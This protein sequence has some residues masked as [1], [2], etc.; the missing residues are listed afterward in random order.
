MSF[1]G[2]GS[3]KI[4]VFWKEKKKS[5]SP[6][7]NFNSIVCPWLINFLRCNEYAH[8]QKQPVM[9]NTDWNT[10][11]FRVIQH[12]LKKQLLLKHHKV[13][14]SRLINI[15][16]FPPQYIPVRLWLLDLR[17]IG[18]SL[19]QTQSLNSSLYHLTCYKTFY[20][21]KCDS[22]L[23]TRIYIFNLICSPR[24]R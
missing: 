1:P 23:L 21:E 14:T 15:K 18:Q 17:R 24:T 19:C 10:L 8:F 9:S 2:L 6:L 22:C 5:Q 20:F 16:Y 4:T 13:G 7:F 12:I 3:L 11:I